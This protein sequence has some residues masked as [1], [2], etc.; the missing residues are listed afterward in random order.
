[1]GLTRRARYRT[2]GCVC[3]TEPARNRVPWLVIRRLVGLKDLD[4]VRGSFGGL[5]LLVAP[6]DLEVLD[7]LITYRLLRCN[8]DRLPLP[9]P[10]TLILLAFLDLS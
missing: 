1:M 6:Y 4:E 9:L 8:R 3:T 10:F 5:Y 7:C 2:F